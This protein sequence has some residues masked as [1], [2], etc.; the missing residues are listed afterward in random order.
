MF[1][2]MFFL[3]TGAPS[4]A[5]DKE[6]PDYI[7]SVF[8][9]PASHKAVGDANQKYNRYSRRRARASLETADLNVIDIVTDS[10]C[11]QEENEQGTVPADHSEEIGCSLPAMEAEQ[12]HGTTSTQT[13]G[14]EKQGKTKWS[15][16]YVCMY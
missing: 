15:C 2:S 3:S 10:E 1:L 16:M 4:S 6:N 9:F 8:N 14:T 11:E 7:P 5:G 13:G 12:L